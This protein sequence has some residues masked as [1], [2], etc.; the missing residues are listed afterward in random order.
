[1]Y[2]S[3]SITRPSISSESAYL[4]GGIFVVRTR[5]SPSVVHSNKERESLRNH[6]AYGPLHNSRQICRCRIRL[7]TTRRAQ[8]TECLPSRSNQS[9]DVFP[10]R[11]SRN[12]FDI[13]FVKCWREKL[14]SSV[15]VRIDSDREEKKTRE[16]STELRPDAQGSIASRRNHVL[17]LQVEFDVL[18]FIMMTAQRNQLNKNGREIKARR[19]LLPLPVQ[20]RCCTVWSFDH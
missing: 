7:H 16:T 15:H 13:Y 10:T 12:R 9:L 20:R 17:T 5:Y 11:K 2:V 14:M 3:A 4:V 19:S 18:N 8:R 1:M 6:G